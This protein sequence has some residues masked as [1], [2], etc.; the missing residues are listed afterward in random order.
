LF[1]AL[2]THGGFE[3]EPSRYR[4]QSGFIGQWLASLSR[5]L[6]LETFVEDNRATAEAQRLR[7]RFFQVVM[8]GVEQRV[9]RPFLDAV[10]RIPVE[11]VE[12]VMFGEDD[13]DGANEL[14]KKNKQL[15]FNQPFSA[16]SL[17]IHQI[18]IFEAKVRID[19]NVRFQN[20]CFFAKFA[21]STFQ[22]GFAFVHVAFGKIPAARVFHQQKRI[23]GLSSKDQE[24]AGNGLLHALLHFIERIRFI[25]RLRAVE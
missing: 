13:V 14:R 2:R 25:E 11:P 16:V 10:R 7:S 3:A 24:A 23:N 6:F 19:R 18:A 21:Q 5:I 17:L 15:F 1:S 8:S 9:D 4:F 12:V 20:A 22:F